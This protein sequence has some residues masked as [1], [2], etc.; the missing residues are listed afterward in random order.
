MQNDAVD[1]DHEFIVAHTSELTLADGTQLRVRPI[2]PSDKA[3]LIDGVERLSEESRYRRFLAAAVHLTEAQLV[4]LTEIDYVDHFAWG[5]QVIL[6]DDALDGAGVARYVRDP[7]DPTI[8]EAAVA[9]IDEY[10]G[11]GIGT[12][13]LG[14]LTE[15]ALENGIERFRAV[16]A[17]ANHPVRVRLEKLGGRFEA[18]DDGMTAEMPLPPP[19]GTIV[20]SVL[21]DALRAVARGEAGFEPPGSPQAIDGG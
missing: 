7:D 13:L 3:Q 5:A 19:T 20:D 14:L 6:D 12:V 15:S 17:Y 16:V 11:M 8:A 21:Y 10:Q 1:T 18:T 4:Y 9:V 2:V